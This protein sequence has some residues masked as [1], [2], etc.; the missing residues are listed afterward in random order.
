MN[1]NNPYSTLSYPAAILIVLSM[2]F[3]ACDT[4]AEVALGQFEDVTEYFKLVMQKEEFFKSE[5]DILEDPQQEGMAKQSTVDGFPVRPIVVR[6]EILSID[7]AFSFEFTDETTAVGTMVRTIEGKLWVRGII[8]R[9]PA[10]DT[11]FAK[12]FTETATRKAIFRKVDDTGTV[13]NDWKMVA[14]SLLEG[15]TADRD[16]DIR[17]LNVRFRGDQEREYTDPLNTFLRIGR[18]GPQVPV[19]SLVQF[20][21]NGFSVEVTIQS[22][23]ETP[24]IVYLRHGGGIS[25][26][27]A[28]AH[29]YMRRLQ[30]ELDPGS[31]R[32]ANGLY[33]RTY[34]IDWL[35]AIVLPGMV[36]GEHLGQGR[37]STI[38]ESISHATLYDTGAPVETHYWGVPFVVE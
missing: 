14:V 12:P 28:I 1:R 33:T 19:V 34:V 16:F 38:V 22:A 4:P 26:P 20:R 5:E 8:Q 15:G 29:G 2:L 37:F 17:R 36:V 18:D 25:R 3:A 10:P 11:T 32:V 7:R 9:L 27:G 30:M 21:A 24:E 35:P 31:E 13:E 6:R 23:S